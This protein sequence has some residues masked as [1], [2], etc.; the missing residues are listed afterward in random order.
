[1]TLFLSGNKFG[2]E[3]ISSITQ[4]L[5]MNHSLKSIDLSDCSIGIDGAVH[6]A[7][8]LKMNS[9][10]E[11]IWL[12]DNSIYSQG[13]KEIAD[14]LKINTSIEYLN[15]GKNNIGDAGVSFIVN[16]L[17]SSYSLGSSSLMNRLVNWIG[18]HSPKS[19]N[20]KCSSLQNLNLSIYCRKCIYL[21]PTNQ[22]P[23]VVSEVKIMISL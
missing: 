11:K 3:G 14:A 12:I 15:L 6:I 13:A 10:L 18:M 16:A 4:A 22:A 5:S 17:I 7:N 21:Q 8:A 20:S 2:L 1:M 23:E 19:N 9:A